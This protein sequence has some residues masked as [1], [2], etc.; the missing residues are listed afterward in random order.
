MSTQHRLAFASRSRLLAGLWLALSTAGLCASTAVQADPVTTEFTYQGR[1]Q[2]NG[3]PANG[4]FDLNFQLYKELSGG[5]AILFPVTLE[6]VPVEGGVFSVTLDFGSLA[7]A[8]EAR[9]LEIGVRDFDSSGAFDTLSPR[10]ALTATPYA[11]YAL[12]GNPGPQGPEG[13][14]GPAGETGA[15][16]PQGPQGETGATGATGPQ[17]PS[18][19]V[20]IHT[21]AGSINNIAAGGGT[22]PFVFAGPTVNVTVTSG[23]RI[24]G[25]AVASFG[26]GTAS[27]VPVSTCLCWSLTDAGSPLTAFFPQRLHRRDGARQSE[28][29]VAL[30]LRFGRPAGGHLQG[31]LLHQEQVDR[32]QPD[33]QRLRQRLG[34]GDQLTASAGTTTMGTPTPTAACVQAAPR[35]EAD[36]LGDT[37]ARLAPRSGELGF[38]LLDRLARLAPDTRWWLQ[39]TAE[40]RGRLLLRALQ[41]LHALRAHRDDFTRACAELARIQHRFGVEEFHYDALGAAL[42]GALRELL[43]EDY[44]EDT[45]TAW[46][47]FYADIAETTLA[48]AAECGDPHHAGGMSERNTAACE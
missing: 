29:D 14:Q 39:D 18:G 16:G 6:D 35:A 40:A 5:S 38:Q 21:F 23:Q 1:L 44:D 9:W 17:G 36:R 3:Q 12:S 11:L 20:S 13:P 19:V 41:H 42:L 8:G 31:R 33:C 45:E 37:L 32:D 28:K 2:D 22:V 25:S 26:H 27:D 48:A 34:H 15:T 4:L 46:A 47:E 10:Q 24:T 30:R 43:G 7:F